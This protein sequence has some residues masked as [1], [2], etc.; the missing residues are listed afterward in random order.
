MSFRM[1]VGNLRTCIF[2]DMYFGF[3]YLGLFRAVATLKMN[4]LLEGIVPVRK[5]PFLFIFIK[6]K[7]AQG[8]SILCK[9]EDDW[10]S[11][12]P[13]AGCLG[14]KLQKGLSKYLSS[15]E[16]STIGVRIRTHE[17]CRKSR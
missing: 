7:S 13:H 9:N 4:K 2:V 17:F 12:Y 8:I 10:V 14:R 6:I 16:K 11:D 5:P 15:V 3:D 1:C